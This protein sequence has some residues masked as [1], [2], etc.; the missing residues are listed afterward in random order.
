MSNLDNGIDPN[1]PDDQE[2][3]QIGQAAQNSRRRAGNFVRKEAGN[4]AKNSFKQYRARQA[5]QRAAARTAASSGSAAATTATAG[6]AAATTTATATGAAATGAAG[7]TTAAAGGAAGGAT[8]IV[9]TLSAFILPA[10][11]AVIAF[12]FLYGLFVGVSV[13]PGSVATTIKK[14]FNAGVESVLNI[15]KTD[16]D[17][18]ANEQTKNIYLTADYLR[19]QGY[20]L[21]TEGYIF[22]KADKIAIS[23]PPETDASGAEKI[24]TPDDK[25]FY[26]DD[27]NELTTS[28]RYV[29]NEGIYVSKENKI[30]YLEYKNSPLLYYTWINGYTYFIDAYERG[31]SNWFQSML[32]S[33]NRVNTDFIGWVFGGGNANDFRGM[34]VPTEVKN[35][36]GS[37]R[38]WIDKLFKG[39]PSIHINLDDYTMRILSNSFL[40]FDEEVGIT[41]NLV[42]WSGRYGLPINFITALHKATNAPDLVID[43]IKSTTKEENEKTKMYM[44]LRAIKTNIGLE[45]NGQ[46][47]TNDFTHEDEELLDALDTIK[48][49]LNMNT[50]FGLVENDTIKAETIQALLV[51][52]KNHWFRDVYFEME[53]GKQYIEY[54]A[55]YL[56]KTGEL[57]AKQKNNGEVITSTTSDSWSAYKN[58]NGEDDSQKKTTKKQKV[59][60]KTFKETD[61]KLNKALAKVGNKLDMVIEFEGLATQYEDGRRGITNP[62]IKELLKKKWYIYDGTVETADRINK[63][64][65]KKQG[66]GINIADDQDNPLKKHIDFN[67]GFTQ[68]LS[69]IRQSRDIDA[70]YVFKDLKELLVEMRYFKKEDLRGGVRKVLAWPL[71]KMA[72]P[73]SW[74]SGK[75]AQDTN[76]YGI[77]LLS[78]NAIK[79]LYLAEAFGEEKSRIEGMKYTVKKLEQRYHLEE[80]ESKLSE[81]KEKIEKQNA[82]LDEE[83]AKTEEKKA[84]IIKKFEELNSTELENNEENNALTP[85]QRERKIKREQD[86]KKKE[87]PIY[88][89]LRARYGDG[90]DEKEYILA[91][92]TGKLSYEGD[93]VKIKVLDEDDIKNGNLPA[94]YKEFYETEYKGSIAGSTIEITN[95]TR[96]QEASEQS[97]NKTS[98]RNQITKSTINKLSTEA[99]RKKVE[100]SENL[101][102]EANG[103]YGE[104]VKEGS[105][106]AIPNA[107]A[108]AESEVLDPESEIAFDESSLKNVITMTMIDIDESVID[109]LPEYVVKGNSKGFRPE[110]LEDYDTRAGG[111]F[112]D[113]TDPPN[114]LDPDDPES[115]EI[116]RE[117]FTGTSS[118]GETIMETHPEAFLEMQRE[119]GVN[120][121]FAGAVSLIEN[122][123]GTNLQIGGHNYFSIRN[124]GDGWRQYSGPEESIMDFGKLIS[125]EQFYHKAGLFM[126]NEI[127]PVYAPPTENTPNHWEDSVNKF[128]TNAIEQYTGEKSS[129][130]TARRNKSSSKSSSS[131][132]VALSSSKRFYNPEPKET[133]SN[134]ANSNSANSAN[135]ASNVSQPSTNNSS[136][137][138]TLDSVGDVPILVTLP[139]GNT[140]GAIG[141]KAARILSQRTGASEED[142]QYIIA[143]ESNGQVN[144]ANPSGAYGLFQTMPQFW[145]P[146]NTVEE[147]IEAAYKA[148]NDGI[149]NHGN[150]FH[151]W[152][153]E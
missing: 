80:D 81:L 39:D 34:I 83:Y 87:D 73:T 139:N 128:M 129:S 68:A 77:K 21:Y 10:I 95:V 148:Y 115:V 72:T 97:S 14:F 51:E 104:Y 8:A 17:K 125:G 89:R 114:V 84:E 22:K 119:T 144:A 24:L 65:E 91:P 149:T 108:L 7:A 121:I 122:G 112:D 130:S 110:V 49:N 152:R 133:T 120:A 3:S 141:A 100:N 23:N 42:G 71:K 92:A 62:K 60:K 30:R 118:L 131:A 32:H 4:R 6:S 31:Y 76:G 40:F 74:P 138:G 13:M 12:I 41:Y 142:W 109:R 58:P 132:P 105:I 113:R 19:A 150:G 16:A 11:I 36:D 136:S 27:L 47:I 48:D 61:E 101:K 79:S 116:F 46:T 38:S 45:Y 33:I 146:A 26:V 35:A 52:V 126:V 63:D 153:L 103:F 137:A 57:W 1:I 86:K 25:G 50:F 102:K 82:K 70:E 85:E 78:K 123:G 44:D 99:E 96:H 106:I 59:N 107:T 94:G 37:Q 93:T 69:I 28:D 90:F 55:D 20:N 135:T 147:Q 143:R 9:S 124:G 2:P 56:I 151:H 117:M 75:E 18:F 15:F 98:Y 64:R 140:A 145:G 29:D 66:A 134:N 53:S 111:E 67:A 127:G 43:M 88:A 54:D 5:A